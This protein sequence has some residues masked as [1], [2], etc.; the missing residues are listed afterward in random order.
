[1]AA[2][3][4]TPVAVTGGTG[5]RSSSIVLSDPRALHRD[6]A[7]SI[8]AVRKA[9][10][11]VAGTISTFALAA[12]DAAGA[13]LTETDPRTAWLRQPDPKRTLAH[14]L[15]RS[16]DD[17]IW[18]DRAVWKILDRNTSLLPV[19]FERIAPGRVDTISN[20]LDEDDIQVWIIDGKE[21]P[22]RDL[23]PILGAGLG[24]LR[25]FGFDLLDLYLDLQTAAGKYAKA[26]HPKAV[27]HNHGGDLDEPEIQTLLDDWEQSRE[28][29]S[30]GYLNDVIDYET[31]GW[32]AAELQ[33]NEA[34]EYAALE[35][36]RMFGL[37]ARSVDASSGDSMTYANVVESRRD[38]LDALRPWMAPLEQTLSL[39][40][41]SSRPQGLVVP[42]GIR[43]RFAI[44]DYVRDTPETR[45]NTW[46]KALTA[47]V[48]TL[49]EVRAAEPLA[50]STVAPTTQEVMP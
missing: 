27:L 49:E 3:A 43:V 30:V 17:L 36:A 50:T 41:R 14:L 1:M 12:W 34:R 20:P 47:G 25:R 24:G 44:D 21:T 22:V 39:D 35:V 6:I 18:Y 37:P 23:V 38:T 26:P 28:T 7:R 42:Y 19:K 32:N 46:D 4:S 15:F 40:D 9:E 13:K 10:H 2:A 48:L 8:P 33:L 29:R 31:F 11:V 45:M 16:M 5:G